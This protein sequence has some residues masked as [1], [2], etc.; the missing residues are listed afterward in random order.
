M[1]YLTQQQ[2]DELI[3]TL[4][5]IGEEILQIYN[6][7]FEHKL[8]KDKSPLTKADML[9]HNKLTQYLQNKYPNYNIIS[10]EDSSNTI[11]KNTLSWIIDPLDGT[12]DFIQKTDEFSIMIALLNESN[13]P[14]FGC[15]YLPVSN[16]FYIAQHNQGAYMLTN[17]VKT[18]LQT[19]TI[20]QLSKSTLVRS[21][22][23]FSKQDETISNNLEISKFQPCGS[24]GVKFG[25]IAQGKAELCYY[26]TSYLGIWDC[27]AAHIIL[28]ESG[29]EVFTILGNEPTYD[30]T[31]KKMIDGFIGTNGRIDKHIIIKQISKS[32][33]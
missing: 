7:T 10:E 17:N 29:G 20:S 16:I 12:K 18:I 32:T 33:Q 28:Q 2:I 27:T 9:S 31:N 23:H 30:L 26:S 22:N 15:V 24:V 6:T 4:K 3:T 14:I 13:T 21:R 8:K 19:S 5:Y 11:E 25:L 1:S